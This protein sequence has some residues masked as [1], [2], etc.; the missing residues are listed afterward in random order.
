[1]HYAFPYNFV[2]W[3][4][5]NSHKEIKEKYYNN[6]LDT[7]NNLKKNNEWVGELKTSYNNPSLNEFLYEDYFTSNVIWPYF[8]NMLVEMRENIPLPMESYISCSW[9]NLYNPGDFQETH[10]HDKNYARI[11]DK[12]HVNAYCGIYLL[13]LEETN[14]TIFY[15]EPPIPCSLDNSGVNFNTD[16]L[17]EGSIIFFPSGLS[18]YVLPAKAKRC[19]ISFN[20]TSVYPNTHIAS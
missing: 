19:T 18:H 16:F 13:H 2:Y 5:V 7:Q 4:K 8:D 11:R 14:K 6:I 17:E 10:Q 3:E 15:E 9:Y 20:I 1:M 12:I